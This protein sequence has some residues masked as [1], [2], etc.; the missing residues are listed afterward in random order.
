MYLIDDVRILTPEEI[1]SLYAQSE[2]PSSRSTFLYFLSTGFPYATGIKFQENL[3][4]P[5]LFNCQKRII[6]Y[7]DENNWDRERTKRDRVIYLSFW[8][9]MNLINHRS[10]I[11]KV[12]PAHNVLR[13]NLLYWASLTGMNPNGI[14]FKCVKRTRFIYLLKSF[15]EY[16]DIIIKSENFNP[17]KNSLINFESSGIDAY[18]SIQFNEKEMRHIR[19]LTC[20]WSGSDQ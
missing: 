3:Y 9:T 12:D 13:K 16:E 8:D 17:E 1:L 2:K 10:Y 19:S 11:I 20:G 6:N 4:N 14:T 15:P 18:R 5:Q 7:Y